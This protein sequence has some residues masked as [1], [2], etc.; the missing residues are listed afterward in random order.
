MEG[1]VPRRKQGKNHEDGKVAMDTVLEYWVA[2]SGAN[3]VVAIVV[4]LASLFYHYC[5]TSV[6]VVVVI[7]KCRFTAYIFKPKR[8]TFATIQLLLHFLQ[9]CTCSFATPTPFPPSLRT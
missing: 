1:L 2:D 6:N 8:F 5:S 9:E 3:P 4:G 7:D